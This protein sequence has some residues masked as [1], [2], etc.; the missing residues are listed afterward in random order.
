MAETLLKNPIC[1]KCGEEARPQAL[2][3]FAC[4]GEILDPDA[5]PGDDVS[6]A[7]FRDE[8][9]ENSDLA[10][11]AG[12][13]TGKTVDGQIADAGDDGRDVP[14]TKSSSAVKVK[15]KENLDDGKAVEAGKGEK[16]KFRSAAELRRRPKPLRSKQVEVVWQENTESPNVPFVVFGLIFVVISAVLLFLAFFLK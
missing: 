12:T 6:S 10:R 7:W 13:E 9:V 8:I 16:K 2:F 4:G 1:S 14:D 3:C 11:E 15:Q 5:E